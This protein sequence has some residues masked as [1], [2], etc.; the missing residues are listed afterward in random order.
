MQNLN[1]QQHGSLRVIAE[2]ASV[3]MCIS[4]YIYDISGYTSALSLSIQ[5]VL[6]VQIIRSITL[7]QA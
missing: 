1:I 2:I 3:L 6:E 5:L 4:D 7:I